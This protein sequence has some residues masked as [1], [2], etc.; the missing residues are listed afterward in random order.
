MCLLA[1]RVLCVLRG[2]CGLCELC[3]PVFRWF[4]L[5]VL[6]PAC[7]FFVCGPMVVAVFVCLFAV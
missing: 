3:A 1:L 5:F 2:L 4:A 7:A 6:M